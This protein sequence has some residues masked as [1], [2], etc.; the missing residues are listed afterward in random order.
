[1]YRSNFVTQQKIVFSIRVLF[2]FES[3]ENYIEGGRAGPL[4]DR[5]APSIALGGEDSL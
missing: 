5:E 3:T 2:N 1:M 4:V